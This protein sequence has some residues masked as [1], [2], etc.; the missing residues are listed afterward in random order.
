MMKNGVLGCRV[1][2]D[3]DWL[4]L[5]MCDVTKG[6]QSGSKSQKIEYLCNTKS[7]GLKFCKFDV[8]QQL[9]ILIVVLMSP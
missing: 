7:T 6:T 8:L 3:F 1:I 2:Q 5:D 9:H 4:K